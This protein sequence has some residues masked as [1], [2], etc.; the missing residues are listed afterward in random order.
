MTEVLPYSGVTSAYAHKHDPSADLPENTV[1]GLRKVW[2]LDAQWSTCPIEVE[3]QVKDLWR[4]W[5]LGNDQ[6]IIK[7]SVIEL[8]ELEE[9]TVE[10]WNA[11]KVAWEEKP[12]DVT[13]IIQY[14]REHGIADDDLVIIQWWW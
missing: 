2:L 9:A 13:Y 7:T 14:I 10:S 8:L 1:A 3:N 6:S 4:L 5:K 11:E 12:L